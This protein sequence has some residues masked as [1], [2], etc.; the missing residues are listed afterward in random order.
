MSTVLAPDAYARWRATPLGALVEQLEM[1]VV[2]DL[3]GP[4]AGKRVLAF[5]AF[6]VLPNFRL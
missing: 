1:R 5:A 4:L 3:A 2:F 6:L